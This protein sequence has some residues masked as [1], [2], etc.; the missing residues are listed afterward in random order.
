MSSCVMRV[1][2]KPFTSCSR[3][4]GLS[5]DVLDRC[6]QVG[7]QFPPGVYPRVYAHHAGG[8]GPAGPE[9]SGWLLAAVRA[10]TALCREELVVLA[11]GGRASAV[12][13]GVTVVGTR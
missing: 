8:F 2:E 4:A 3:D 10:V 12:V 5:S 11:E 9:R 7:M 13:D 6:L 1:G